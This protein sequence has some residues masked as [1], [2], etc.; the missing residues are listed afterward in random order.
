MVGYDVPHV[1]HDMI[2]RFMGMNFSAITE[3]SAKIP[4]SLG[5]DVKPVPVLV[6]AEPTSMPP[7]GKSKE[8]NKAMWEGES[9]MCTRATSL[10]S[11]LAHAAYYNAGSAALVLVIIAVLIAGFIWWRSRK[12]KLSGVG[13]PLTRDDVRPDEEIPLTQSNGN[14]DDHDQDADEGSR[15]RKGKGR[16][17]G[18][19]PKE[20][21]FG[22]GDDE[23]DDEESRSPRR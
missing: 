11:Q 12:G 10:Y 20:E 14:A 21:I 18:L 3:G 23:F 1:S 5:S 22:V 7:P 13:L 2:L 8:Q 19:T 16:A 4:S 17:T 6:D 9:V 15:E